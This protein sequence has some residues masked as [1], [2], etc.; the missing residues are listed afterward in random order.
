MQST[1]QGHSLAI[2]AG[3]V[4][5]PLP[6]AA[7]PDAAIVG[8]A[9]LDTAEPWHLSYL[10]NARHLDALRQTRAGACLVLPRFAGDAPAGT[11]ALVVDDPH[12]AY[13]RLLALLHPDRLR[14]RPIVGALP[15]GQGAS[16]HPGA[17][18]APDVLLGPGA[19]IG[20]GVVIGAGT[21]I[22]SNAVLG[23]D[24]EIGRDGSVAA[25][26]TLM[27]C[28]I[29]DRAILH[30]GVR[31][32]QDGFG[33]AVGAEG[34]VKVAQTGRVAIGHDVEI[35]ANTTIDRGSGRDTVIGDGCKIDNLVQIAHNVRLGRHCVIVAQVGIAGSTVVE[36]GV[37]IGGQSAIAGHLVIG[38]GAQLAASS[39]VMR[40]VPPGGR[41]GGM[42]AK[43]LKQW[44]RE[45]TF[46]AR[47][48]A[49]SGG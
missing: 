28:R 22:G 38:R 39:R 44:F 16:V 19:V 49:R 41:W 37:A 31:I 9:S 43:P 7:D 40:N 36:D 1:T 2:L 30:P 4:G 26:V 32:G 11:A 20:E 18:I 47:L 8:G 24:V 48:A 10:D 29:G 34:L 15:N 3:L 46:L 42:P 12:V 27:H 13:A 35:G 14:G 23:P 5:A 21:T 45:Q 33:F 17:V 6:P 25:G